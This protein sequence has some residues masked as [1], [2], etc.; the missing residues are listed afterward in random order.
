M[1]VNAALGRLLD[2]LS[3]L[4][5]SDLSGH[6][7][8]YDLIGH[9]AYV[10]TMR[11]QPSFWISVFIVEHAHS[12][13]N[14]WIPSYRSADSKGDRFG[15]GISCFIGSCN[16]YIALALSAVNCSRRWASLNIGRRTDIIANAIGQSNILTG[17]QAFCWR[18]DGNSRRSGVRVRRSDDS[19]VI[20]HNYYT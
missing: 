15:G 17:D 12:C 6:S 13:I 7:H 2:D 11:R 16:R 10:C 9:R 18:S 20:S 8:F 19:L 3:T 4:G 14:F 1:H 5:L